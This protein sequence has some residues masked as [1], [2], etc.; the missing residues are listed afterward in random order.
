MTTNKLDALAIAKQEL[1]DFEQRRDNAQRN[2]DAYQRAVNNAQAAFQQAS[3][4]VIMYEAA[5]QA[6]AAFVTRLQ[7][8]Q[9]KPPKKG[10]VHAKP[11]PPPT[12]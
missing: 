7:T 10:P 6:F 11:N 12:P 3:R 2:A 4:E 1:A 5:F 9:P 8:P